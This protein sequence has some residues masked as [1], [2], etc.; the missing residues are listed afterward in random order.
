MKLS[1]WGT[2]NDCVATGGTFH[3]GLGDVFHLQR[4]SITRV[5]LVEDPQ[6]LKLVELGE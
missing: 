3:W 5:Y 2:R 1:K 6:K 4:K